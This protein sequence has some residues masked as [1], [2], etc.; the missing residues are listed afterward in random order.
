VPDQRLHPQVDQRVRGHAELGDP[1]AADPGAEVARGHPRAPQVEPL[2]RVL[3]RVAHDALEHRRAG[4]VDRPEARVLE[5]VSRLAQHAG[6]HPQAPQGLLAV[7]EGLVDEL[8]V[9][10]GL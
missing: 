4:D 5:R 9:G 1:V 7:A 10:H 2:P 6:A 3:L 8:D